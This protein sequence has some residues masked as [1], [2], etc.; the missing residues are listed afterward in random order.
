M[1]LS[2]IFFTAILL[3]ACSAGLPAQ[4]DD[5]VTQNTERN[6]VIADNAGDTN[7]GAGGM[8]FWT[9][10]RMVVVLA[11]VAAAIYGIIFLLRRLSRNTIQENP[12]LKVLAGVPLGTGRSVHIVS[13]GTKA[14]LIGSA[15]TGVSLIAELTDQEII[16]T[17]L[18]DASQHHTNSKLLDFASLLRRFTGS[19][20]AQSKPSAD[21]IRKRREKL[22]GLL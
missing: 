8:S 3:L 13:V 21:N 17:L 22:G 15:E 9:V 4:T 1:D 20:P 12:H 7:T 19:K 14:W 2:R 16:D 10:F 6:F 18:L 5:P 11:L